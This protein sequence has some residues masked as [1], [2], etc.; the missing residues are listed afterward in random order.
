MAQKWKY[1][2]ICD[3]DDWSKKD[4]DTVRRRVNFEVRDWTD[5]NSSRLD[6]YCGAAR[7]L[8]VTVIFGDSVDGG[9]VGVVEAEVHPDGDI[10]TQARTF[11]FAFNVIDFRFHRPQKRETVP[12]YIQ[13][14][15]LTPTV[16]K[17]ISHSVLRSVGTVSALACLGQ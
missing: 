10:D 11:V 14:V 17:L 8:S 5:E 1:T 3:D 9:V 16:C 13:L 15:E 4:K 2:V 6:K 7:V 12:A